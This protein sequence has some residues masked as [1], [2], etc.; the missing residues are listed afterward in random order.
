MKKIFMIVLIL[1]Y[2]V[3]PIQGNGLVFVVTQQYLDQLREDINPTKTMMMEK[4][5]FPVI[6]N[7]D[8]IT[9]I[10]NKVVRLSK[11]YEP[12]DL[13][14]VDV[15]T[16]GATNNKQMRKEAA[17]AL[18][19]LFDQAKKH[20]YILVA[21]SGYRPYA[22]Q[23]RLYT[24]YVEKYGQSEADRF[25]AMPGHSEHQ[26]GLAMDI[27]VGS[28]NNSLTTGLANTPEGFWVHHNAHHFGYITRYH[29]GK[30]HITGYMYEPWHLRYVGVEL[31]TQLYL[32]DC[33]ME[34]YYLMV[35]E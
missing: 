8:D 4:V 11:D 29:K 17:D 24:N 21:I 9:I 20:N 31:A 2:S 6:I 13:V 27:S 14:E 3:Q 30:E 16:S 7:P 19:D 22:M 25:S 23:E 10:V 32:C 33:T 12:D 26:L 15:R 5:E 18:K 34:E 1:M 28:L 35:S